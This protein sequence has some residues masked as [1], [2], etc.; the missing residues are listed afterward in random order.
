MNSADWLTALWMVGAC[1]VWGFY[2]GLY[3]EL[4]IEIEGPLTVFV[5]FAW[6]FFGIGYPFYL[7]GKVFRRS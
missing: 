4:E 5:A 7:L 1:A 6:P 3:E 2:I